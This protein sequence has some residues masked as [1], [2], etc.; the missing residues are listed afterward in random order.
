MARRIAVGLIAA[1]LAVD[2]AGAA[3]LWVLW[4]ARHTPAAMAA[5]ARTP[6]SNELPAAFRER[7]T[8]VS[9]TRTR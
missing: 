2:V 5:R 3:W 7:P 9:T 6:R 4:T 8:G 1:L